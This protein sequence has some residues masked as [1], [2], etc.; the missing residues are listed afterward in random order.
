MDDRHLCP[1][2]PTCYPRQRR[3]ATTARWSDGKP[4]H[5]VADDL[6]SLDDDL[7]AFA[8]GSEEDVVDA[9]VDEFGTGR[10]G[11]GGMRGREG[12]RVGPAVA[13]RPGVGQYI[14]N[15]T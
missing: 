14:G 6:Q 12:D 1:A 10:Q 8:A 11:C 2:L 5:R 3:S 9:L 15:G 7:L 4:V 13:C